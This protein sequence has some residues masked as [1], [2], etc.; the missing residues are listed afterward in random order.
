MFSSAERDDGL[1][2]VGLM[3]SN[4]DLIQ[5]HLR[6]F[7]A[8]LIPRVPRKQILVRAHVATIVPMRKSSARFHWMRM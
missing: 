6:P 4:W 7:L 3:G 1:K 5:T 2:A 8:F